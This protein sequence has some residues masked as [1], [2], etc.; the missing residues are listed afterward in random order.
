M[1]EGDGR[2]RVICGREREKDVCILLC[3]N[4]SCMLLLCIE[5]FCTVLYRRV[6]TSGGG[7]IYVCCCV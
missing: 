2:R 6:D 7:C 1:S 3:V 4:E 5:I